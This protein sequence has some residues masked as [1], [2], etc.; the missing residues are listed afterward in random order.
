MGYGCTICDD[1]LEVPA[2]DYSENSGR[3][4][5]AAGSAASLEASLVNAVD[6]I[7]TVARGGRKRRAPAPKKTK[8]DVRA[9]APTDVVTTPCGHL[10]HLQC[11][12]QWFKDKK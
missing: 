12:G 6:S 8:M 11:I 5:E 3:P 2:P 10:F 7:D 9:G 1:C 4:A